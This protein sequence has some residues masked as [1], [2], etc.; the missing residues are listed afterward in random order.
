[1]ISK[2]SNLIERQMAIDSLAIGKEFLLRVLDDMDIVGKDREKYS[3][4]LGLVESCINDIKMLPSAQPERKK[5]KWIGNKRHQSCSV[6]GMTYCVP[7]GTDGELDMTFYNFCP[8]CG[9][10]M[11]GEDNG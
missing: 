5:G 6:C 8:N 3:W 11:K 1:M 2:S 4:G 9:A 7:D 10:E